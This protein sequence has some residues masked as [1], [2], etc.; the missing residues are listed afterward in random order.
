M[1]ALVL[2]NVRAD[3]DVPQSL[4]IA[5]EAV[6]LSKHQRAGEVDGRAGGESNVAVVARWHAAHEHIQQ[7]FRWRRTLLSRSLQPLRGQDRD[8]DRALG[9]AE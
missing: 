4:A 5:I 8:D 6:L 1:T 2:E 3:V 7:P 9:E